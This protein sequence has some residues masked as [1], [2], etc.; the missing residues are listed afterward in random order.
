MTETRIICAANKLPNGVLLVGPRHWDT[1]MR[2][3]YKEMYGDN[4]T[5][6]S[7]GEIE[8]GFIDQFGNFHTRKEALEIVLG[9]PV[10]RNHMRNPNAVYELYSEDLY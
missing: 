9:D 8:Q 5:K 3:Q 6:W 2:K 7:H 4:F 10:F 1:T